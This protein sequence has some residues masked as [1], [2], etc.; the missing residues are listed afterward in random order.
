MHASDEAHLQRQARGHVEPGSL[1]ESEALRAID[2][3]RYDELR[4]RDDTPASRARRARKA[5]G[6][7]SRQLGST[8]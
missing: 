3:A 5:W 6:S 8:W 2:D 1:E 4:A 7:R